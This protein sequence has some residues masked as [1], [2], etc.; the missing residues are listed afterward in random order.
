VDDELLA[1]AAALVGVVLAGEDE[2]LHDAL[3]VDRLGD[4]VGVLLDDREE[5]V[6][7]LGLDGGQVLRDVR[8]RAVRMQRA[9]DGPVAGDGDGLVGVQRA[10]RDRRIGARLVLLGSQ[11]ACRRVVSLVRNLSPSSNL[12]W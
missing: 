4:L 10:A 8:R 7:Q 9:V 11:A 5:V 1:G 2:G 3:A 12:S 6:Q